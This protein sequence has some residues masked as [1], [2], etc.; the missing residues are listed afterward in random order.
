MTGSVTTLAFANAQQNCRYTLGI[1][2]QG[3]GSYTITNW[4]PNMVWT[5]HGSAPT[6]TTTVGAVD[7]IG[8][9]YLAFDGNW[10]CGA[11]SPNN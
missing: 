8:C 2:Q 11:L 10:H 4:P 6:L 7:W 1:I 5:N 3:S 9:W